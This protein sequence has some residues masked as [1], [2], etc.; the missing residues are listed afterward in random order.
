MV[1]PLLSLLSNG[2]IE[3]FSPGIIFDGGSS[4]SVTSY[5]WRKTL[6]TLPLHHHK[7][8]KR[9]P[10]SAYPS[11][12]STSS[13]T[14]LPL[15]HTSPTSP[16]GNTHEDWHIV[17]SPVRKGGCSISSQCRAVGAHLFSFTQVST[18]TNDWLL[19]VGLHTAIPPPNGG[20][21]RSSFTQYEATAGVFLPCAELQQEFLHP[22]LINCRSSSIQCGA[23]AGV[24]PSSVSKVYFANTVSLTYI[25]RKHLSC[26]I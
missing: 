18:G 16:H 9:S 4:C 23:T 15:P 22:V 2:H 19:S 24:S 5:S 13:P 20:Y 6:R 3:I 10:C 17:R 1:L 25:S 12:P 14:C 7:N 26:S 8:I 11:L 21:S